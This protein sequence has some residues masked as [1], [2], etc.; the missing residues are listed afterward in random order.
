MNTYTYIYVCVYFLRFL[1]SESDHRVGDNTPLCQTDF[2]L[3]YLNF[4][5]Y[6]VPL[7]WWHFVFPQGQHFIFSSK[8]DFPSPDVALHHIISVTV[9]QRGVG[10]GVGVGG[11]KWGNW[12]RTQVQVISLT[13]WQ[14]SSHIRQHRAHTH[15]HT[16]LFYR[17]K[18]LQGWDHN[19]T[20]TMWP[21]LNTILSKLWSTA[22]HQTT[23]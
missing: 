22:H 7:W 14:Q 21:N 12:Y 9:T 8:L 1:L 2:I 20:R 3:F 16:H 13:A 5:F 17:V 11:A 10:V 23:V 18:Q 4:Y 19:R 6:R 15:T